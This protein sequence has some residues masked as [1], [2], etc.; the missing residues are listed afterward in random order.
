MYDFPE[1]FDADVFVGTT[2]QMI[3]FNFN[4]IHFQ[5]E[6]PLLAHLYVDAFNSVRYKKPGG[7]FKRL[8]VQDRSSDLMELLEL[9]VLACTIDP[10]DKDILSFEFDGQYALRFEAER[11]GYEE[12]SVRIGEREIYI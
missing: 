7:E 6:D 10:K 4:T 11:N 12:Y 5:F 9:S 2:L 8:T 1:D 3:S